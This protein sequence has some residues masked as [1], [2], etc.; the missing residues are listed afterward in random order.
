MKKLWILL[1][2]TIFIGILIL[3]SQARVRHV[4][5]TGVIQFPE[6]AIMQSMKG[7]LVIRDFSRVLPWLDKQYEWANSYGGEKN[8]I[9]NKNDALHQ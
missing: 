4:I 7:G 9:W 2:A 8:I 6:F 3:L 1:F 5:F